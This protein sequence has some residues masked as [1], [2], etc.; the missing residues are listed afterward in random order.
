[1]KRLFP[2]Y[3][4]C[5]IFLLSGC[6]DT[7][8]GR[9]QGSDPR[10]ASKIP[11]HFQPV[12][13]NDLPGWRNDDHRY[14]LQ[15][16]RNT[17]NAKV[18]YSGAVVMDQKLLDEKCRMLPPQSAGKESVRAWFESNFQPYKV[19]DQGGNSNGLFTG[20]YS[21]IIKACRKKT[22]ECN[23]PLMAPPSDG[24]NFKGIPRKEIVSKQI[25]KPLYWANIVDVQNIQ[26]QGS[27]KIRLEN[28]EVVK[29]NFAGVN[30]MP[31]GSI[32]EYLR[33]R[34]I[35][36]GG[37]YSAEAVWEHLRKHPYL[38]QE[39]IN[40]NQRYVYFKTAT[41]H[42][43][44]G[45]MNAPLSKIRSVAMDNTIYSLGMPVYVD[46]KLSDGKKFQR[47]MVAQDTGGAIRG[48]IR[49]DLFFGEGEEAFRHAQGQHAQG[50]K[51]ILMPKQ[52]EFVRPN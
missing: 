52:Y 1:M 15:A 12:G 31:F 40:S 10:D 51:Y 3:A 30:D 18:D 22:D 35:K 5:S 8:G 34:N 25:G 29:L 33:T 17:C 7:G 11:S 2:L 49:V 32:G 45:A 41:A 42:D 26:I 46:T 43:V 13:Y 16:F 20:Y 9:Y 21:P 6:P 4:L 37:G 36:P 39:A 47:L 24:R 38:A 44:I 19:R 27:G 28:G 14:A 23:E 48:W 50:E